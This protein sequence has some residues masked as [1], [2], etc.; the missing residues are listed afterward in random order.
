VFLVDHFVNASPS[1]YL[2]FVATDGTLALLT[3]SLL[4][5]TPSSPTPRGNDSGLR[6][7]PDSLR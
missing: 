7:E 1:T 4:R 2:L 6:S 3:L 5:L